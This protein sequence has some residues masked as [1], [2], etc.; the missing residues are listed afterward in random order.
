M[1]TISLI[2]ALVDRPLLCDGAMGTQLQA[3]GLK[4]GQCGEE[5]NVTAA[6]RVEDVHRRYVAAG[7]DLITTN[8][9]GGTD[10]ALARH[11]L[12][13]RGR[14]F[15]EAGARVAR[16]AA[17]P[18]RWVL[19]DVGPLGEL[20]EPWGTI[21]SATAGRAFRDQAAALLAG[22]ADVILV[23]TMSDPQ[24]AAIA[25]RGAREAGARL[26]IATFAFQAAGDGFRTMMGATARE[27]V[28]AAM[29][30]GASIVGA[31]CGTNL[32]LADYVRLGRELVEAAEGH[33][34]IV[35]PNAGAPRLVNGAAV[36]DESA[37]ELASC[38]PKFL[39][40]GVRVIGGC[41]GTTPEH[42]AAMAEAMRRHAAGDRG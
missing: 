24:E 41:C 5:W 14:E 32:S 38:V 13:A 16:L 4:P 18:G 37:V 17:G 10:V 21:S 15:N 36:Y 22:G 35:Q 2:E 11:G 42:L 25:A 3:R 26:V 27:C 12:A 6:A 30:G 29:Q 7:C 33:P 8:T 20:L 31:N 1:D 39:A 19:G 34:V 23:E 40:A 28:R 9:F